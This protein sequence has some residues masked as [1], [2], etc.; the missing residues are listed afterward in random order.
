MADLLPVPV[1]AS[2]AGRAAHDIGLAGLLGGSLFGR[3]AFHPAVVAISDPA[4]RGK[5]VN[6]TWRRSGTVNALSLAAVTAGWLGARADEASN[7]HLSRPERRLAT[8]RDVL[9]GAVAIT[10]IATAVEGMRFAKTAPDGAVPLEDGDHTTSD[11]NERQTRVKRRL[12]ILGLATLA[13]ETALVG[14]NS[15]LN[16]ESFR[17]PPVRRVIRQRLR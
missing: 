11:A 12:N 10:G 2:K 1:A 6:A 15:A 3:L 4:E 7:K 8:M 9:L 16:Q 5:V 14:V 13:S 17:R